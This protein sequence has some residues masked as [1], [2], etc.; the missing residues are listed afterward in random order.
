MSVFSKAFDYAKAH[1]AIVIGGLVG[2][3]ALYWLL[4]R[5]NSSSTGQVAQANATA[6]SA[7]YAAESAQGTA[8]DQLAATAIAAQAS[9]AQ[10]QIN[11]NASVT[12]N[13]TWASTDLAETLSNNQTETTIAP[14]VLSAQT[15]QSLYSALQSV[16][17]LPPITTT[18]TSNNS[19][20][21][22]IGASSSTSTNVTANPSAT[23][24]AQ[25]L[26]NL[27]SQFNP[28]AG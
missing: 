25:E 17:S 11:A 20:F 21:L 14:A 24:A 4:S 27:E 23:S 13:N 18:S 19:G 1:P 10:D 12:N 5:G 3:A 9:T 2:I 7:Y 6:T 22:G 8:G 28:M 16:A 26:A 15:Q